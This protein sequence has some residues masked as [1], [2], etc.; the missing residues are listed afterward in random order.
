MKPSDASHSSLI[1]Y[2]IF[3]LYITVTD[4]GGAEAPGVGFEVTKEL[5]CAAPKR[6]SV[7]VIHSALNVQRPSGAVSVL[8]AST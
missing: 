2:T 4:Q 6:L 8:A 3:V 5:G 7:G 1:C